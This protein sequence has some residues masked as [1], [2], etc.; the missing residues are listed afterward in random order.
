MGDEIG[1][2]ASRRIIMAADW[3]CKQR[4]WRRRAEG[5]KR[6]K[7]AGGIPTFC[8]FCTLVPGLRPSARFAPQCFEMLARYREMRSGHD[9]PV[10]PG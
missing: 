3:A 5:C 8:T 4:V 7:G 10:S 6:C 1:P 2:R 9:P